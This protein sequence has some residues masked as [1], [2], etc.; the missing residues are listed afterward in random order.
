MKFCNTQKIIR[1][2]KLLNQQRI[3][4]GSKQ[5]QQLNE[6]IENLE[7]QKT[8]T[9]QNLEQW[10][11]S[12]LNLNNDLVAPVVNQLLTQ[13]ESYAADVNSKEQHKEH[14]A[15]ELKRLNS[16]QEAL[17]DRLQSIQ[18]NQSRMIAN[19]QHGRALEENLSRHIYAKSSGNSGNI[20]RFPT[21]CK[22]Q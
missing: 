18:T 14:L 8:A 22:Q 17:D 21:K 3:Y 1:L 11:Q 10:E 2:K 15:S 12:T 4:Q 7:K 16:S 19:D 13:Y 9:A 20:N 5:I 6:H